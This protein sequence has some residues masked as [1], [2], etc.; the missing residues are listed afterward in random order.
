MSVVLGSKND[1]LLRG[2]TV[3]TIRIWIR[4]PKAKMIYTSQRFLLMPFA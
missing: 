3:V 2:S 4:N 1:K